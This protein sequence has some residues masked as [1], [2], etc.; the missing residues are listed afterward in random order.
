MANGVET[1]GQVARTM[2]GA[3]GVEIKATIPEKQV[4]A[5]LEAVQPRA[6]RERAV[7]LLL[8]YPGPRAVR[9]R[10]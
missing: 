2:A 5:A 7:H 10:E 4:D 9:D 3:E 8:R 6:R 1:R